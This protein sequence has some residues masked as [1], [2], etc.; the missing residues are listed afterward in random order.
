[1]PRIHSMLL[2]TVAATV[3]LLLP[4][5]ACGLVPTPTP[6]VVVQ[7]VEV[8][9]TKLVPV[10]VTPE[11]T[12]TPTAAPPIVLAEQFEGDAGD[13]YVSSD[14]WGASSV[15]EGHLLVTVDEPNALY[16]SGHPDLDF[17][18][19]PFD[20]TVALANESV[21]RD[22][23]GAVSFRWTDENNN[24]DVSVNGDGFISMGQWVD[25]TYYNTVPWTRPS[26]SGRGPYILRMI[27]TGRRVTAYLNGELVF[28]IPFEDLKLG[29][30]SFFVGAYDDVPATW[31][32][33]DVQV[34]KLAP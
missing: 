19:Q 15:A 9:V 31:S 5:S 2:T 3:F 18:N 12:I 8:P 32:F 6:Q 17:L 34:S 16:Y 10:T 27:D 21:P 25:G 4:T 7:T 11:P 1:M 13:W 22:A 23:Y 33:D 29:G 24:A 20:L 28:D 26:G 30:V 14:S